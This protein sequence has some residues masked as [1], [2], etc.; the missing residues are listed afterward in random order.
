MTL[1]SKLINRFSF[2]IAA[3][4]T[5]IVLFVLTL[6]FNLEVFEAFG[7]WLQTHE[8]YE[9]DEWVI[10]VLLI[11]VGLSLDG[12]FS[13][14]ERKKNLARLDVYHHMN[15]QLVA[16]VADQLDQLIEIR[17]SLLDPHPDVNAIQQSVQAM[18]SSSYRHFERARKCADVDAT[19]LAQM[20]SPSF[21]SSPQTLWPE[22]NKS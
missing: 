20:L 8:E 7:A 6:A 17:T 1:Y 18:I 13:S 11:T 10:P 19:T 22:P 12:I 15:A 9:L 14:F 21:E 4:A 2:T 5:A 16:E 3:A